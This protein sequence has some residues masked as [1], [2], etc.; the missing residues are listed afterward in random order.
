MELNMYMVLEALHGLSYETKNLDGSARMRRLALSLR[1]EEG[2]LSLVPQGKDVRLTL[3]EAEIVVQGAM[4]ETVADRIL[5]IQQDM[6]ALES[7]MLRML[8]EGAP[9]REIIA[10]C[11]RYFR[12]FVLVYD[13][14]GAM[15]EVYV[16]PEKSGTYDSLGWKHILRARAPSLGLIK[17]LNIG[18]EA[19]RLKEGQKPVF[20]EKEVRFPLHGGGVCGSI[21]FK[22]LGR[23]FDEACAH[24]FFALQP[25]LSIC[26]AAYVW[27]KIDRGANSLF[28]RLL[29][30]GGALPLAGTRLEDWREEDEKTLIYMPVPA[31][32]CHFAEP[33]VRRLQLILTDALV[34]LNGEYIAVLVNEAR[35]SID[36]VRRTMVEVLKIVDSYGCIS[37]TFAEWKALPTLV[38]YAQKLLE[39]CG[40]ETGALYSS[41]NFGMSYLLES[42]GDLDEAY[43]HPAVLRLREYDARKG[44]CLFETLACYLSCGKKAGR[45]AEKLYIHRN[46][47]QYRLEKI[48]DLTQLDFDDE[49]EIFYLR[50]SIE[51]CMR[52]G[53]GALQANH[54]IE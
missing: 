48:L 51:L 7:D 24:V 14:H 19:N 31:S 10:V 9:L 40:A 2:V 35:M 29:E 32:V 16:P 52:R 8:W 18:Y 21:M 49:Q 28:K 50:L 30:T 37:R 13:E 43:L 33:F 4:A 11:G 27:Q 46:T 1:R 34:E 3:G 41:A 6:N 38:V 22:S 42:I 26:Y 45:T 36:E 53:A 12:C 39:Q 17:R 5:M 44:S 25:V 20:N 47:L 23:R 54:P 15:E